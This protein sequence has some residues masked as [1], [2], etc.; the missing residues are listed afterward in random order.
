MELLMATTF[1]RENPQFDSAVDVVVYYDN[2]ENQFLVAFT[3][4]ESGCYSVNRNELFGDTFKYP[5][6]VINEI[7]YGIPEEDAPLVLI[8]N[9]AL[10]SIHLVC[11]GNRNMF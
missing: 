6:E 11:D 7:L 9:V 2:K 4:K 3:D 5:S 1:M 8:T 10:N